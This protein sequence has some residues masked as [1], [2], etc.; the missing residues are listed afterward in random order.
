MVVAP[1]FCNAQSEKQLQCH[2]QVAVCT[3]DEKLNVFSILLL[4]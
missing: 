1:R 3:V 4:C 2:I